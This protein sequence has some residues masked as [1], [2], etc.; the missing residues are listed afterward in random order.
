[1]KWDENEWVVRNMPINPNDWPAGLTMNK[2][3]STPFVATNDPYQCWFRMTLTRSEPV[4]APW[5]GKGIFAYGET[6]DY[7]PEEQKV[8]V[9]YDLVNLS[10]EW[11][12]SR[13]PKKKELAAGLDPITELVGDLIAEERKDDP[14]KILIDKKKRIL[15]MLYSS[16]ELAVKLGPDQ[17]DVDR[18][19]EGLWKMM[20]FITEEEAKRYSISLLQDTLRQNFG[21]PYDVSKQI[22]TILD[23]LADLLYEQEHGDPVQLLLEKKDRIIT[24]L[25]E[26]LKALDAAK[27]TGPAASARQVLELMLLLKALEQPVP[28]QPPPPTWPPQTPPK[29]SGLITGVSSIFQWKNGQATMKV[30]L[31]SNYTLEG[32]VYDIE[33]Y[34]GHQSGSAAGAAFTPP[35]EVSASGGP[36]GWNA[37][38]SNVGLRYSGNTPLVPCTPYYFDFAWPQGTETIILILTYKEHRPIGHAVSQKVHSGFIQLNPGQTANLHMAL[39]PEGAPPDQYW[40]IQ[41]AIGQGHDPKGQEPQ[42]NPML[43]PNVAYGGGIQLLP[44]GLADLPP[45]GYAPEEGYG[46]IAEGVQVG[47]YYAVIDHTGEG[48]ALLYVDAVGPNGCILDC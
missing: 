31:L 41:Y 7:G 34:W 12:A 16:A 11:A 14:V 42:A 9:Y 40:D 25:Q 6:E 4:P 5:L 39:D 8:L 24:L 37:Q 15:D 44:H 30:H 28:P 38:T 2:L 3:L 13:D 17:K 43:L 23:D 46:P 26:L 29:L 1:M 36:Q 35:A 21:I 19:F 20:A 22:Q 18:L 48:Y 27:L 32:K 10:R 45:G 47:Q 33:I